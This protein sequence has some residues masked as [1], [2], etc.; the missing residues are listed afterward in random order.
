MNP[1]EPRGF[2]DR[3]GRLHDDLRISVT[4]RCNLRCTYCMPVEPTWFPR[5]EILSY[6]EILAVVRIVI[7][8][9]VRKFRITGGE[10]LVRKDIAEFVR[11]LAA[12][13]GVEDLSLTT[14]GLLLQR[15]AAEL[16][17]AGLRRVNVS[18]DTLDPERFR[19]L[20]RHDGLAAVLR[21]M[22]AASAA[23]LTPIKINVVLLRDQNDD[24]V[25]ALVGAGRE[26]GWEMRFIEFMPLEN[27]EVWD[28]SRVVPGHE[29]RARIEKL[30]PLE[31]DPAGDPHAPASRFLFRDG[32]GAVGFIDSVTRPF[33]A[34]CSRLRL[35]S[36]GQFRV[37]L[38]D[39]GET[40]LKALLRAG[41]S[42]A[43]IEHAIEAA[44]L[45]KGRGGAIEIL[46]RRERLPLERTMHQIG[47]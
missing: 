37:C 6:E 31:R 11:M 4:D 24:E 22:E 10:P 45:R 47:G 33:C 25:E 26:R 14:N 42:D 15:L 30:W 13:G 38:Y 20:T 19:R 40:D 32:R 34:D 23:G 28:L 39:S 17:R 1:R 44:V 41:A 8:R 36:D 29:V 12:T 9:G 43:E 7:R 46:E 3:F 21:G 27:G 2:P 16:A 35:T 5:E 18:L